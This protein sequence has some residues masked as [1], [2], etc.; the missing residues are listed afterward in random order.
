MAQ[1]PRSRA[2]PAPRQPMSGR[3]ARRRQL[4][5]LSLLKPRPGSRTIID[6]STPSATTASTRRLSSSRTSAD[7]IAVDGPGVHVVAV[8]APVHH[9]VRHRRLGDQ[10]GHVRVGEAAAHVVDQAR[11]GLQGQFGHARAHRVH[12]DRDPGPGQFGDDRLDPADLLLG[13]DALRAGPGRFP[14]DV[15]DVRALGG[16]VQAVGHGGVG[17]EP[18]AAVGKRVRGHV[19]DAHHQAAILAGQSGQRVPPARHETAR[20][21]PSL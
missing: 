15:H 20:H 6:G 11:S 8:A 12:A 18:R 7:H 16:E 10:A 4:C 2:L 3:A 17:A 13:G 14:A 5:S 19:D 9:H 1:A 21:G